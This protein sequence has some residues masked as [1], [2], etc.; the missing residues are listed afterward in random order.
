MRIV[1]IGAAP[2]IHTDQGRPGMTLAGGFVKNRRALRV[3]VPDPVAAHHDP[4]GRGTKDDSLSGL[5]EA[6]DF[7]MFRMLSGLE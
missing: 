2:D 1:A 5:A 6:A 7:F 4:I 3:Q